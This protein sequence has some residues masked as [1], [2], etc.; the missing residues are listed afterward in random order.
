MQCETCGKHFIEGKKVKIEGCVAVCCNECARY[1]Q[2]VG[3]IRPH[4]EPPKKPAPAPVSKPVPSLSKV[5]DSELS[6]PT[7]KEEYGKLIKDAREK[8]GL[9]MEDFAK[10]LNEP[11]SLMHRIESGKFEPADALAHKIESAL[12]IKLFEKS[13]SMI[14]AGG[15]H[16]ASKDLTLGDVVVVKKKEK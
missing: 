15:R 2:V 3:E 8:R 13:S 12:H 5:L 10:M 6:V 9:K 14:L 16:G 7:L 11:E 1:G 4:V